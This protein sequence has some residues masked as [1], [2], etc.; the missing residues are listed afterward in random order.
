M[1][2]Q[3]PT[4]VDWAF[5]ALD[6]GVTRERISYLAWMWDEL[7]RAEDEIENAQRKTHIAKACEAINR[8]KS[9]LGL[10]TH[11]ANDYGVGTHNTAEAYDVIFR[12]LTGKTGNPPPEHDTSAIREQDAEAQRKT[13]G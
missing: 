8:I 5:T 7:E 1:I 11:P 2:K 12:E 6:R 13:K 10:A 4:I 3:Y 9:E